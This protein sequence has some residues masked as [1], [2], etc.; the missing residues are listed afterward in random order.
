MSN[1][2]EQD[3]E[4]K[5]EHHFYATSHGKGPHDGV[6]GTFK[7]L[8]RENVLAENIS[9]DCGMEFYKIAKSIEKNTKVFFATKVRF[10]VTKEVIHS[11]RNFLEDRWKNVKALD[12]TIHL[13]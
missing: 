1:A 8:V 3:F 9:C 4:V 5:L 11:N 10:F 2:T 12:L 6:G 13:K 7:C